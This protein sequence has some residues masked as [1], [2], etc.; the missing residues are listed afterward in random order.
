MNILLRL[1]A[2]LAVR[3]CPQCPRC[4]AGAI[5]C[6]DKFGHNMRPMGGSLGGMPA[7]GGGMEHQVAGTPHVHAEGHVVCVYQY[8]TLAEVSQKLAAGLFDAHAVKQ[9]HAWMHR[10]E[11]LDQDI[12]KAF[13]P[14]IET[15][16][17]ERFAAREHDLMSVTPQ[18]L[19][20][21][22]QGRELPTIADVGQSCTLA[23]VEAEG[24][25]FT[26]VYRQDAQ[27]VF[28]RVQHHVHKKTKKG[29]MPLR[30]CILKGRK[31]LP[32]AAPEAGNRDLP[33]PCET[34]WAS[35]YRPAQRH[36]H[37][38]GHSQLLVAEWQPASLCS[39]FQKQL[40]HCT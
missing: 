12:Y 19:V 21:E 2:V 6:Q 26:T 36:R 16:W 40:A 9:Y 38:P 10:E 14:R 1:A 25:A 4:N 23:E 5:S 11:V 35:Y 18:Y 27:F 20:A 3:M 15:E 32:E 29:Y 31:G 7:L 22:A 28:S 30:A 37:D 17:R 13:L 34:A 39:P 24:R 8:N 33:R